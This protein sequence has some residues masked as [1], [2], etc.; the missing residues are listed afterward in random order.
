MKCFS[1][2]NL[3][4]QQDQTE[5]DAFPEYLRGKKI[6]MEKTGDVS[7]NVRMKY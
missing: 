6:C 7:N 4:K 5:I 1:K 2:Y 3:L